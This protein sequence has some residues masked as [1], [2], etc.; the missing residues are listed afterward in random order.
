MHAK[1]EKMRESS[2]VCEQ[3]EKLS[4]CVGLWQIKTQLSQ[5]ICIEFAEMMILDV[6]STIQMCAASFPL[7]FVV[8]GNGKI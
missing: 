5:I 1:Y 4:Y 3:N 6:L 7:F 2:F 8:V